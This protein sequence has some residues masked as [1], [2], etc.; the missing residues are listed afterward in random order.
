M[1]VN[2]LDSHI[3]YFIL[4]LVNKY[5]NIECFHSKR[6]DSM[7]ICGFNKKMLKGL[8]DFHEGLIEHGLIERSKKK[9]KS[10]NKILED[11]LKD[12]TRFLREIE[13]I[14]DDKKK[15]ILRTITRYSKAFYEL[16]LDE[17]VENYKELIKTLSIFYER[18]DDKYYSELEGRKNDMKNLAEFL[19][20]EQIRPNKEV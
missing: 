9:G 12:M 10:V 15:E 3:Y 7:P 8:A 17:G 11:E 19:D 4:F 2:L 16:I 20:S 18:M 13:S 14:Q 6:G 1:V 5:L